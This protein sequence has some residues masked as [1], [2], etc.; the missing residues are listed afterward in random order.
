MYRRID[1]TDKQKHTHIN[2]TKIRN[3]DSENDKNNKDD[4]ISDLLTCKYK[5]FARQCKKRKYGTI[6]STNVKIGHSAK[7]K[8]CPNQ[9]FVVLRTHQSFAI[10]P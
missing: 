5:L 8:V 1:T 2:V 4:V 6:Q 9:L 10:S 7:P 3:S